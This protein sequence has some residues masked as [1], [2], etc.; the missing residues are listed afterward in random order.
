[1]SVG[2]DDPRVAALEQGYAALTA[3]DIEAAIVGMH[4]EIVF[5]WS[6]SN[7]PY[8]GIYE[9]HEAVR[10]LIE[11]IRD[12]FAELEYFTEEWVDAGARLIRVGGV[13]GRGRGSGAE[14]AMVGAQ[15]IEFSD[16]LPARVTL[17]QTKDEALAAVG[18]RPEP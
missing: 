3:G 6:R 8:Q 2:S 10:S 14:V 12:A 7:S 18:E 11:D 17:Y 13:R 1:L 9:G 15:V 4:P 16:G 5:D